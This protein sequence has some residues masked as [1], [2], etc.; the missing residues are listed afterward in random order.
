MP[1]TP[2]VNRMTDACEN[3]TLPQTSFAGGKNANFVYYGKTRFKHTMH[4]HFPVM[5]T[6]TRATHGSHDQ[7]SSYRTPSRVFRTDKIP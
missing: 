3:I 4:S 1:G 7:R 2:P 5:L 6:R